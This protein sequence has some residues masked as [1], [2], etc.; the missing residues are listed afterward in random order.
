MFSKACEYAIRAT[1]YISIKSIAGSKLGIKEIAKEIDSPVH[2]TAKIL[3]TLSRQ[4]IISSIKGPHGGFYL[5]ANAKPI[6]LNAIVIAI[7]GDNVLD[8][9]SLGLKQCSDKFPCPIHDDIKAYKNR[10]LKVMKEKTVQQLA[11][12]L[13]T[14]KTFLRNYKVKLLAVG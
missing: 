12:E 8:T 3:Q 4:G 1:L 2:F 11:I 13:T 9:C 10:L 6:P 5:E 14:G 7:D